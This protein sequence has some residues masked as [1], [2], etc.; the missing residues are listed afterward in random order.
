MAE[1]IRPHFA[2]ALP[3]Q[4]IVN[5][6]RPGQGI[7]MHADHRDFGDVVASLSLGADW[8]MRFRLRSTR[9]YASGAMPGDEVAVLPRR[10]VLVLVGPARQRW[11]HGID[12]LMSA[13]AT[14]TR[15]SATFRTF[16]G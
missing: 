10:S 7:G 11:M 16:A 1:R 3:V 4:C 6:Y 15:V 5:E 2:G 9:P 14:A 13:R 8:P 12:R